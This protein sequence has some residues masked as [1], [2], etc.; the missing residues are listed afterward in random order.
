M[1]TY[2]SSL[3]VGSFPVAQGLLFTVPTGVTCV[4]RDIEVYTWDVAGT[5]FNVA[6]DVSGQV[7]TVYQVTAADSKSSH[8]WT[9]RTVIPAGSTII[10]Q[11]GTN[12]N[13]GC[14]SGYLLID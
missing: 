8:Q 3:F 4:I 6:V 14:I 12:L 5:A 9:G 13:S 11:A 7:G 1:S 2:S 10:G